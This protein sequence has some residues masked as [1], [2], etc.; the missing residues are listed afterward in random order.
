MQFLFYMWGRF[1]VSHFTLLFLE[2]LFN[3][4]LRCLG[5]S[6][7]TLELVVDHRTCGLLSLAYTNTTAKAVAKLW[8]PID[9][10]LVDKDGPITA[11]LIAERK[12][13]FVRWSSVKLL[14]HVESGS[15]RDTLE[16]VVLSLVVRIFDFTALGMVL[17]RFL[18]SWTVL[19]R[20]FDLIING[21][22]II[23]KFSI[24]FGYK[25]ASKYW[26]CVRSANFIG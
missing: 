1:L 6:N 18:W 25:F 15:L 8:L 21:I 2:A 13:V 10:T 24:E 19:V 4:L 22:R 14:V 20:L 23:V 3:D 11:R 12:T 26:T 9:F 17:G 16:P 5:D 7:L